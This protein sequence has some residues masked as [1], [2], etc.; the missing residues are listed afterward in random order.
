M[1]ATT[2]LRDR[3]LVLPEPLKLPAGVVLP[4]QFVHVHD[5]YAYV[6]GHVPLNEDGSIADPLGKVGVELSVDDGYEAAK[7]V[8]L[9]MLGSL[10]RTLGSLERITAWLRVFGM[11]N[12]A[13]CFTQ[14]A[15]V[16]NGFS[17]LILDVFG[18]QEAKHAR[19]A[20]GVAGLPFNI[21]VEVEAV[22]EI[23]PS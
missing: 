19:S 18:E 23:D 6:S 4:F 8:G 2:R 22:I 20:I 13:P 10:E 11:V 9:A 14:Q 3:G 1:S 15:A 7:K 5:R 12:Q 21:P 17:E 16:I